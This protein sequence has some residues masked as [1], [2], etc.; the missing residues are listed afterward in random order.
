MP[1]KPIRISNA[2]I[3]RLS[4][5]YR[6]LDNLE[7]QDIDTVLS[8]ELCK[9][10]GILG[11]QVRRDLSTFGSFGKKGKGYD[12]SLLK[13]QI[14]RI[15]G[16]NTVWNVALIGS[17]QFSTVLM[18]SAIFKKK[19]LYITKLFDETP[20]LVGYRI[21]DIKVSHI[22]N[23]EKE[24]DPKTDRLA[25]VAVS[26]PKIQNVIDRL[27]KIGVP[28]VFYFASRSVTIPDNM[29]VMHTDISVELGTLTYFLKNKPSPRMRNK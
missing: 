18:H 11:T 27:A 28:G 6:I 15:L 24:I 5:Y 29:I 16:L 21:N 10:E 8:T 1:V 22:D 4:V 13:K 23:L 17:P 25:M 20:E 2:T 3:R 26:P 12:V 9:E 14:A 7:I 19:N